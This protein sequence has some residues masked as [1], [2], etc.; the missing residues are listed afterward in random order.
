LSDEDIANYTSLY[1]LRLDPFEYLRYWRFEITD[2]NNVDGYVEIGRLWMS[3]LWQP[4]INFDFGMTLGWEDKSTS[5][6]SYSGAEYFNVRSKYRV[7]KFQ[8][9]WLTDTEAYEQA[10]EIQRA[11]GTTGEVLLV[12]DID[13]DINIL[14]RSMIG[15]MRQL[16][17]LDIM[18]Y[19]QKTMQFEIKELV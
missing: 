2:T 8:L 4:D 12:S 14:R 7:C 11:N 18:N 1:I 13:D 19:S 10:F 5:D 16:P 3:R 6:E 15:R 9:S 17:A